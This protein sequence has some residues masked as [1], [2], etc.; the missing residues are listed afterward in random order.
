MDAETTPAYA[1]LLDKLSAEY[2][3]DFRQYKIDSLVRRI[4]ARMSQVGL[5]DVDAYIALLD[6][7]P[8]EAQALFNTILINVTGFFRDTAAWEALCEQVLPRLLATAESTGTLRVWSAGC[9]TG[10]EAYSMAI[11]LADRLTGVGRATDVK[12]YATDVDEDALTVARHGVYRLD[13]LKDVSP[14]RVERHFTREGQRYRF[15]RDL[16]RWCIF[17]RHNLVQ[18]PPLSRMDLVICRNVLIYFK[19]GLQ[20]RVIPRLH[21][22]LRDDGYLFLGRSESLLA[23]SRWFTPV[24][25]KWRIFQRSAQ[26]LPRPD[27]ALLRAESDSTAAGMSREPRTVKDSGG[28]AM[29]RLVETL[30]LAVM[31][32]DEADTIRAWNRAAA[33]L[34]DVPMD[35]VVGK[36]FRDLDISY[37]AEGLRARIEEVKA[38]R[39]TV[40]LEDV[41]FTRRSGATV[42]AEIHVT[43]L[44]DERQR[45][46][47]VMVAGTDITEQAH[48]RDQMSR[49]AEQHATATEEL[50]STNEELETTNEE[51]QSTNEE[52]E[53]TNEEL[54]STNE[55]LL[56][57][58]EELQAAT[59]ETQRLALYHASVVNS[60]D[61]PVFV[62]DHAFRVTSWNP[63]AEQHWK[64]TALQAI[65]RDF[66]ALPIGGVTGDAGDAI[67]RI[68]GGEAASMLEIPFTPP[69]RGRPSSLRLL[70]LH[71]AQGRLMGVVGLVPGAETPA[72]P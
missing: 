39:N 67:R 5:A 30:P 59:A 2:H 26:A 62:L 3:F 25:A 47:G 17:G 24:A 20:D 4:Q 40:R 22:A 41:M 44:L 33:T 58:M 12:I 38:S 48:L 34:F 68:Q 70:P 9:S 7:Q 13:Q 32:V 55:E 63:A 71:D 61:Q 57:T 52:L 64:L 11:L 35:N 53:T 23:R 72:Q 66:F 42:H 29:E 46:I 21:Y 6:R 51:L 8:G 16:R 10:E 37:R 14:D 60:V 19:S 36:K 43:P 69:G 50:Q 18:D 31:V 54:Q 15:R 56:S 28:V 49:L 27:A 45:F 65:G 1:R